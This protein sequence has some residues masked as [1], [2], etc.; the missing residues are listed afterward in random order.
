MNKIVYKFFNEPIILNQQFHYSIIIENPHLIQN[1]V[2]SLKNQI[3]YGDEL[4]VYST[5]DE[6]KQSLPEACFIT[7]LFNLSLSDKK[8]LNSLYKNIEHNY[9]QTRNDKYNEICNT[10]L[11]FLNEMEDVIDLKIDYSNTFTMSS[12][13]KMADVKLIDDSSSLLELLVNYIK[14]LNELNNINLIFVINLNSCF[15]NN[16]LTLLYKELD[17]MKVDLINIAYSYK[18]PLNNDK[19]IVIDD[20][21]CEIDIGF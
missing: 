10:I 2:M 12:I 18:K 4:L 6:S 17:L 3:E 15:D 19:I 14:T 20:D 21:L 7:D 16:E 5:N 9:L 8:I 11:K 1:F 13:L